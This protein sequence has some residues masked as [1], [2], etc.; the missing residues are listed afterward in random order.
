M[1]LNNSGPISLAGSTA[2]QSIALELG[3]NTSAQISLN[4]AGPRGLAG[5][6]SGI[7]SMSN[8]YGKSSFPKFIFYSINVTFLVTSA[9]LVTSDRIVIC[10]QKQT[11]NTSVTSNIGTATAS[12]TAAFHIFVFNL[13]GTLLWQKCIDQLEYDDPSFASSVAVV[14]T[15]QLLIGRTH[16]ASGSTYGT[17]RG[18]LTKFNIDNGTHIHSR[19]IG[20]VAQGIQGADFG[21]E[22][23]RIFNNSTNL[24]MVGRRGSVPFTFSAPGLSYAIGASTYVIANTNGGIVSQRRFGV[25]GVLAGNVYPCDIHPSSNHDHI[26]IAETSYHP[27]GSVN[28]TGN[29]PSISKYSSA[30]VLQ[31]R[32]IYNNFNVGTILTHGSTDT[33]AGICIDNSGNIYHA[34]KA[35]FADVSY[36]YIIKFDSNLNVLWNRVLNFN[37]TSFLVRGMSVGDNTGSLFLYVGPII[38]EM[39]ASTGTVI[40][41]VAFYLTEAGYTKSISFG[42]IRD[43][44]QQTPKENLVFDVQ[45]RKFAAVQHGARAYNNIMASVTMTPSMYNNSSGTWTFSDGTSNWTVTLE[46]YSVTTSDWQNAPSLVDRSIT[47]E[48]ISLATGTFAENI[49]ASTYQVFVS[50]TP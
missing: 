2:G 25:N 34:F 24:Y 30:G 36:Q 11:I 21:T 45:G 10:G 8:F 12:N 14:N 46:S 18:M 22:K 23:Y 37:D 42:S 35:E 26:V 49:I 47:D 31:W 17:Y 5:V 20:S 40:K 4:D 33:I 50:S 16:R 38:I 48:A 44:F 32:K 9:K 6:L 27:Q 13:S 19:F 1:A 39:N 28:Q 15:N 43:F 29:F 3:L 41:A 7:I